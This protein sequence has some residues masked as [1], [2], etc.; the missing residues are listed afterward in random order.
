VGNRV[1][2]WHLVV[3]KSARISK[4]RTT[5][6][7]RRVSPKSSRTPNGRRQLH[8]RVDMRG[9]EPGVYVARIRYNFRRAGSSRGA[10]PRTKVH[11]YRVGCPGQYGPGGMNL[12]ETTIL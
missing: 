8:V 2:R 1:V 12:F 3:R 9:L 4:V 10:V 7:G 6:N 5:F 11:Y